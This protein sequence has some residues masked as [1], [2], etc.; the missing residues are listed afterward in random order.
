MFGVTI[1]TVSFAVTA[2][3]VMEGKLSIFLFIGIAYV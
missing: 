3:G 2:H 1:I